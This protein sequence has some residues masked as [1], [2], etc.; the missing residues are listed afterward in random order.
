MWREL[1]LFRHKK[2]DNMRSERGWWRVGMESAITRSVVQSKARAGLESVLTTATEVNPCHV[3][4]Q[5]IGNDWVGIPT[6]YIH[7]I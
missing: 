7:S 3:R 5:R 6:G 1:S 4:E 2:R